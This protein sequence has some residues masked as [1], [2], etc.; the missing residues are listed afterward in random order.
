MP[1]EFETLSAL[2]DV[3]LHNASLAL[4]AMFFPLGNDVAD[5]EHRTIEGR[6]EV[7]NSLNHP[8]IR[9]A[10]ACPDFAF[11]AVKP[12]SMQFALRCDF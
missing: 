9:I 2:D 8:N 5:A 10:E 7:F 1:V 4:R 11:S 3:F 6:G 12:R